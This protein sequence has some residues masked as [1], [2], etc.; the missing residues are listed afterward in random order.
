MFR[1]IRPKPSRS[2]MPAR[3]SLQPAPLQ[4]ANA[5]AEPAPAAPVGGGAGAE[6]PRVVR[7]MLNGRVLKLDWTQARSLV[8]Q[9]IKAMAPQ[10]VPQDVAVI[11]SIV[12]E[13]YRLEPDWITGSLRP[14]YIVWPRQVAMALC[15]EQ[16]DLSLAAVGAAFGRRDHGTVMHAVRTVRDVTDVDER[17]RK[18]VEDC[19]VKVKA[20]LEAADA[21]NQ[22]G[23]NETK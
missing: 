10:T 13:H 12:A 7:V 2:T 22:G 1:G 4:A 16:L 6:V 9:L 21:V 23:T 17:R 19:R 20:A 18:E 8:R 14:E 11:T 3:S 15:R 5:P